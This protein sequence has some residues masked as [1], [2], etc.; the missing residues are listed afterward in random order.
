MKGFSPGVWNKLGHYI[1]RLIDPRSGH[2]FYVGKGRDDRV[3]SHVR[4]AVRPSTTES[5][6]TLKRRV[7]QSIHDDGLEPI[8][9]IHRHGIDDEKEALTV[10]AAVIDA[11]A[12]LTNEVK[13][14]GSGEFGPATAEQ[15]DN[16]Y[17]A[18]GIPED[19]PL[20]IIKITRK[21][22]DATREILQR[23][24]HSDYD[25]DHLYYRTVLGRW[26]MSETRCNKLNA[27]PHHVL[28]MLDGTCIGVY[29]P[30]EWKKSRPPPPGEKQRYQF[31]GVTA[32]EEVRSRYLG[33]IEKIK[34]P[35]VN[36]F[37]RI[38]D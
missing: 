10:E 35:F 7:I 2:T 21:G 20:V 18:Q 6:D 4:N 32:A 17:R 38:D 5:E 3:F 22:I 12:T 31:T 9:V 30:T 11:F 26:V 24:G 15:L 28:A 34:G 33:K 13:G 36:R 8:H 1:Y 25:T 37:V 27:V 29:R 14:H 16:K 19:E 23:E